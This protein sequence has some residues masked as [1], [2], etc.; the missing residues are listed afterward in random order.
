MKTVFFVS[1]LLFGVGCGTNAKLR[2]S[3]LRLEFERGRA[4]GIREMQAP[5]DQA[6]TSARSFENVAHSFEETNS[7]NYKNL[8]SCIASLNSLSSKVMELR[9]AQ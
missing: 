5:Y 4:Q 6:V 1:T 7:R 8:N 9:K 3:E 2:D